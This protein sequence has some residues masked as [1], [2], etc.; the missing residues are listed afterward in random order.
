MKDNQSGVAEFHTWIHIFISCRR[1]VF[2]VLT[3]ILPSVK[4][5]QVW[6]CDWCLGRCTR[7]MMTGL[8]VWS[9]QDFVLHVSQTFSPPPLYHPPACPHTP[10]LLLSFLVSVHGIILSRCLVSSMNVF[11]RVTVQWAPWQ[12]SSSAR[13]KLLDESGVVI[14]P[15]GSHSLSGSNH[16]FQ[17]P[18]RAGSR[19]PK[20]LKQAGNPVT[21]I[22]YLENWKKKDSWCWEPCGE[23][24]CTCWA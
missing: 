13:I 24:S 20:S 10:T 1:W 4:M 6:L 14:R 17:G 15:L 5:C 23:P 18:K 2:A 9:G 16:S 11:L 8:S 19:S 22:E 21:N 12:Y 3:L 7:S